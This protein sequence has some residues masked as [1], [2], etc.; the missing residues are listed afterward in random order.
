MIVESALGLTALS[1]A[2]VHSSLT[3]SHGL[4]F[5]AALASS[6]S[7]VVILF[8][9]LVAYI[10]VASEAACFLLF[11]NLR[12]VETEHIYDRSSFALLDMCFALTTFHSSFN[13]WFAVGLVLL[14]ITKCLHWIIHDR[15]DWVSFP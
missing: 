11:G 5:P 7:T 13:A 15:V 1:A 3:A 8:A 4:L 10:L 12:L 14:S 2:V 6:Q 9:T